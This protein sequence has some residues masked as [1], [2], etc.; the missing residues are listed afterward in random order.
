MAVVSA[1]FPHHEIERRIKAARG[2]QG[3]E[4]LLQNEVRT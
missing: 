4:R 2:V 3:G 1:P